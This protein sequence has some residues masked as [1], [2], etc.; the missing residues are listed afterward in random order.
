[1]ARGPLA[2]EDLRSVREPCPGAAVPEGR[3]QSAIRV[4]VRVPGRRPRTIGAGGG[5][6]TRE[7]RER[8]IP[9][10]QWPADVLSGI[11][12]P[13]VFGLSNP[14]AYGVP[15]YRE[16]FTTLGQIL[17][18]LREAMHQKHAK[19]VRCLGIAAPQVGLSLRMSSC[20]VDGR[21]IDLINPEVIDH[22]ASQF[23]NEG[24]MSVGGGGLRSLIRVLRWKT[25]TVEYFNRQ[26]KELTIRPR[27]VLGA[28]VLQHEIDHLNGRLIVDGID[29]GIRR[30][31]AE[32]QW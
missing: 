11:A 18:C 12:E 25:I 7:E 29:P 23:V 9:I 8:R 4:L 19:G 28:Q 24:R 1:M 20:I 6:V 16:N 30:A 26:G 17:G 21:T 10:I 15:G 3:A 2:T 31:L 5:P 14:L 27:T 13:W 32:A 22:G